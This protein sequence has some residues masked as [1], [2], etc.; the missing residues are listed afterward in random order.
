[1]KVV[2]QWLPAEAPEALARASALL[3]QGELVVF[4][5]DTV[6][7]VGADAFSPVALD[8]LY[9]AKQ[10]PQ[11]K[12]L[13]ILISDI[14][15]LERITASLSE[16]QRM[17]IQTL[18]AAYWPGPLTLLLPRGTALPANLSPNA[19]VAVRLPANDIARVIIRQAG[20]AVATSSANMSG[21]APACT[22]AEAY[23]ALQGVVAAVVDGGLTPGGVPSTIVDCTGLDPQLVRAGPIPFEQLLEALKLSL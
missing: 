4:P 14:D 19:G 23:A 22:A 21:A 13:P 10:R 6:Y 3:R 17:A 9:Q 12:G 5:T 20:G 18:I 8:H 7:G 1:M 15:Q 16:R 2:T 11:A